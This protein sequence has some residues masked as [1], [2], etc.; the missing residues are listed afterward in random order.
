M[1]ASLDLPYLYAYPQ[2]WRHAHLGAV[3]WIACVR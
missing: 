2:P 3:G 1:L